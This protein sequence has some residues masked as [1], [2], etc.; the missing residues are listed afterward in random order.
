MP[1]IRAINAALGRVAKSDWTERAPKPPRPVVKINSANLKPNKIIKKN[2]SA[3]PAKTDAVQKNSVKVK[4]A[5][6]QKA[7]PVSKAKVNYKES[8]TR[9]RAG[10][11]AYR[12]HA[13]D[14]TPR[15]AGSGEDRFMTFTDEAGLEAMIASKEAQLSRK[16]TR[17]ADAS[18]PKKRGMTKI[19]LKVADKRK[20]GK[21]VVKINSANLKPNKIIKKKVK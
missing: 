18:Q 4:P 19:D 14:N 13:L 11:T 3:T 20:S 6:R 8:S 16:I 1:G 12:N 9:G 21:P 2:N 7:S 10:A 5:A 15:R 17:K